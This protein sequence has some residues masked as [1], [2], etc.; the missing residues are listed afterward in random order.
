MAA[1]LAFVP[2][3]SIPFSMKK[4][5]LKMGLQLY[6]IRDAM[7]KDPIGSLKIAKELGYEDF[8]TFGYDIDKG[9]YYG[10][11]AKDFKSILDDMGLSASSGHYDFTSYFE[12]SDDGMRRFVDACIEGAKALDKS[13]I[14]WPWL[15][16]KYRNLEGF[17]KM[18]D[19]LNA[20]G[21]QVS[22]SGLGFAYH[23]HGFEFEEFDGQTG[24][25]I[26]VKNTDPD[27]VKLQLDLYWVA[28]SSKVGSKELISRDPER[29]VMWHIKD[30]DKV[31][32][33]YSELGNG[34]IDYNSLLPELDQSGLQFYYLEQGGNYAQN[35]IQSITDSAHHFKNHLKKYL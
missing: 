12:K 26:I 6:T 31:T 5:N 23:N 7:A 17:K 28:H 27:L 20:I 18:P 14:T 33:D 22:Q 21:E 24:Y 25:D 2:Y 9:T 16:P 1:A 4:K 15:D 32:R 29:Y 8:E 13:Y 11:K 35:D 3:N 10:F 19:K 30:M 34:S